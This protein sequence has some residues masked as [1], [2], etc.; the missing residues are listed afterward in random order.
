M[1]AKSSARR[2]SAAQVHAQTIRSRATIRARAEAIA[3]LLA[4]PYL[5]A[6]QAAFVAQTSASTVRRA[7]GPG[8]TLPHVRVDN[9][10]LIRISPDDLRAWLRAGGNGLLRKAG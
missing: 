8:G 10:K 3:A 6:E 1:S 4:L 9:K 2:P 5:D 7:C